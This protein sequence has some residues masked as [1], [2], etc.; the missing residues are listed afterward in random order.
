VTVLIEG[1]LGSEVQTARGASERSIGELMM[2]AGIAVHA[3]LALRV[4]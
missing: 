3:S 4:L 1:G 2:E